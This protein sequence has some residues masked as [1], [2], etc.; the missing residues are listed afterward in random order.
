MIK[1]QE[2]FSRS[3][4]PS[5]LRHMFAGA[6]LGLAFSVAQAQEPVYIGFDGAYGIRTNTAPQSIERGIRAAMDEINAA[7]G[8]LG[9]RPLKLMTTDNQ[10]IAA[11]ARDNFGRLAAQPD[12]IAVLGGKLSPAIVESIPEAQ[13]LKLPLISIW[14]SA[15]PITDHGFKPTFVFRLSLKD[16]WGVEAL[17]QRAVK[18]HQAK[19]VCALLP[20]TAWGRSSGAVLEQQAKVQGVVVASTRW[21]NL[22]E[23]SFREALQTC[24]QSG[25]QVLVLVANEAEAAVLFKDMALLP[26]AD[27]LPVIAHWGLTGGAVHELAGDALEKIDLEVI[28]TFSFVD[29][30]RPAAIRLAQRLMKDVDAKSVKEIAS[31]VG[32][33]QAYDMTHLLALA[34]NVAGAARGDAV[35][36]ALEKLPAH[37]GAVRRYAPAFTATRHDALG[38]QQVLFVRVERSGALTPSR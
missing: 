20:N 4:R 36:Q 12:L 25:S 27:R 16:S 3:P 15:D 1:F 13:R 21:F 19:R 38:P 28:Q 35:R 8:V 33:A 22:G 11:R 18:S 29:N 6:I 17:L 24:R 7:G 14:G 23:T 26:Q 2:L 34:V 10:G 31:P 30:K 9:G 5:A 37:E 32:A